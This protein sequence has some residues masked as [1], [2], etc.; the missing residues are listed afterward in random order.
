[1]FPLLDK[2]YPQNLSK[3]CQKG[4]KL[5]NFKSKLPETRAF[6]GTYYITKRSCTDR[7]NP[8]FFWS[9]QS[10]NFQGEAN[11]P[12]P[13]SRNTIISL[14]SVILF[15]H[16]LLS[17]LVSMN[18]I[19][20]PCTMM[21]CIYVLYIQYSLFFVFIGTFVTNTGVMFGLYSV[22]F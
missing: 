15:L 22:Q 19:F 10:V 1:M 20:N 13:P 9:D 16:L 7:G 5:W 14:S 4:D 21:L 12:P 6:K 18:R 11:I 17:F 2:K 3:I 8:T